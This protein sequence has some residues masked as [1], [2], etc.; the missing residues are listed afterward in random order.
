LFEKACKAKKLLLF[1]LPQRGLKI[2]GKIERL[3]QTWKNEFYLKNYNDLSINLQELNKRIDVRQKYY[4]EKR[5]QIALKDENNNLFTPLEFF[6][7]SH[8]F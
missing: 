1:V 2:N 4:N 5:P 7:L 3:N 6:K 8:I